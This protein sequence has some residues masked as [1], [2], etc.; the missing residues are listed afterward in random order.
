MLVSIVPAFRE[1]PRN[2][3]PK[4]HDGR[5]IMIGRR[6]DKAQKVTPASTL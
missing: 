4:S 1:E 2:R 3:A 5:M 6:A